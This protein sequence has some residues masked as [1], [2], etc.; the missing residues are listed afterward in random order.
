MARFIARRLVAMLGV[1]FAISVITFAIFN[2][3]PN[4]D[5]A[6]R[7]AGKSPT[8]DTLAAIRRAYGF[9]KPVPV[10]HLKTMQKVLTADLVSYTNPG[11]NVVDAIVPDFP[12]T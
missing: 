9:D 10:Q 3:I 6:V 2:V 8:P 7:L 4:G 12:R 1:L 5:P 11:V